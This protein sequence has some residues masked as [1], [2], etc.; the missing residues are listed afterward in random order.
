[1]GY[2]CKVTLVLRRIDVYRCI[3]VYMCFFTCWWCRTTNTRI[4][5][6]VAKVCVHF[7]VSTHVTQV[8]MS[9]LRFS[10]CVP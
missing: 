3:D 4:Y 1:M 8:C 7:V 9:H 6:C 2:M 10:W 5:T